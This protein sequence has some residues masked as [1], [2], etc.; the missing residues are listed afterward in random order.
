MKS[1]YKNSRKITSRISRIFRK[2]FLEKLEKK[3]ILN[4]LRNF[5][6]G[7]S[8]IM[9]QTID[10]WYRY[11]RPE[12]GIRGGSCN[13]SYW[14]VG[15]WGWFWGRVTLC[16]ATHITWV[17]T[18]GCLTIRSR[19]NSKANGL[20]ML[21]HLFPLFEYRSEATSGQS[22]LGWFV[23]I[24]SPRELLNSCWL[25]VLYHIVRQWSR[26]AAILFDVRVPLAKAEHFCQF[27]GA[28]KNCS[29]ELFF[30][31]FKS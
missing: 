15:I 20:A 8:L 30:G 24:L 3:I 28:C 25:P 6:E 9:T 11:Y 7:R 29:S 18:L 12:T 4:F 23:Y 10:V 13:P 19:S 21:K 14:E 22:V 31:R 16:R 5:R 26:L 17:S 27:W 2:K 1:K